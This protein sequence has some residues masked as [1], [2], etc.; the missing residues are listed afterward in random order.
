MKRIEKYIYIVLIIIL[1][2][3]LSAGTTY[4]LMDK[5][6]NPEIKEKDKQEENNNSRENTVKLKKMTTNNNKILQTFDIALNGKEDEFEI[7]YTYEI[8][9]TGEYSAKIKAKLP[10][11]KEENLINLGN[12]DEN[13][14]FEKYINKY[15][16][17]NYLKSIITEDS[18]LFI[19]GD[20]NKNYML[21]VVETE[22][23]SSEP[24][25]FLYAYDDNMKLVSGDVSYDK[26]NFNKEAMAIVYGNTYYEASEEPGKSGYE[27]KFNLSKKY[28]NPINVKIEEN[29]I[30]YLQ[31][32]DFMDDD[33]FV[34]MEERI[35]TIKNNKWIY[36][37]KSKF[38]ATGAAGMSC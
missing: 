8:D 10:N 5:K 27:N 35:Y 6:S 13:L 23:Y 15:F 33:D 22:N 26:C 24:S 25:A 28:E 30:Y 7:E 12:I 17:E 4:I 1:V 34:S 21:I 3:V 19:K 9:G 16:N 18:F 38:K 36:T 20:D 31:V 14:T 11:S 37:V 32:I 29:K 2:G